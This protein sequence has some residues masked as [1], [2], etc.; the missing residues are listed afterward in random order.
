[1]ST[2]TTKKSRGIAILDAPSN[3]GLKPP[4]EGGEPGVKWM[5]Q[6]I[7]SRGLLRGLGALDAGEV[8]APA[9]HD[10]LDPRIGV[11]NA[12]GVAAFAQALAVRIHQLLEQNQFPLVLG[13][14]CSILLGSTL[15][16]RQ[17]GRYGLLFVD[18][19]ADL[20]TP[21]D[22]ITGGAAGMDLALVTGTGPELLTNIEGKKPYVRPEDTVLFGYRSPAANEDSNA[23]PSKPMESF[24][25]DTIRSAGIASATKE[26]INCL[27]SSLT[28]GFW[29]HL[30]V[31]VLSPEW[32]FAVDSPD[33]GGLVPEELGILLKAASQSKNCIGMQV[34][35]YDPTLDPDGRCA[36]LITDLLVSA[37]A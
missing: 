30:D 18:G 9:Y 8:G 10:F 23:R 28:L 24:S 1:M 35:I 15:A 6:A 33:P 3:L 36:D 22:S 21:S 2:N 14:D 13:G 27:E 7:R 17:L 32:M 20:L 12:E 11:R 16:L 37:L 29:L 26:A 31:D 34:T 4:A 5:A 25:L 19:H